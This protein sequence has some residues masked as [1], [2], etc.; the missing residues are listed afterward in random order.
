MEEKNSVIMAGPVDWSLRVLLSDAKL[1]ILTSFAENAER[2]VFALADLRNDQEASIRFMQERNRYAP[3]VTMLV[4]VDPHD[5][6]QLKVAWQF[7]ANDCIDASSMTSEHFAFAALKEQ[8]RAGLIHDQFASVVLDNIPNMVYVKNRNDELLYCNKPFADHKHL[9]QR[10]LKGRQATEFNGTTNS[11]TDSADETSRLMQQPGY[12][13]EKE[14][15]HR[16]NETDDKI[17]HVYKKALQ[18]ATCNQSVVVGVATD[19]TDLHDQKS[20]VEQE[21]RIDP[22]TGLLNRR[23][24]IKHIS[25]RSEKTKQSADV[26]T[27]P[28]FAVI[29]VDLNDFKIVNDKHGHVIGDKLLALVGL[30]LKGSTRECDLVGRIGGDEFMIIVDTSASEVKAEQVAQRI[31]EKIRMPY[32]INSLRLQISCSVGISKYPQDGQ[33]FEELYLKSDQAMY[34]AKGKKHNPDESIESKELVV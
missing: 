25:A 8:S 34:V 22:L 26:S 6:V 7:G 29:L 4:L 20:K 17:F 16:D 12:V 24:L 18:S 31:I 30:R 2:C 27:R 15:H 13:L 3:E 23:V 32:T 14:G 28:T 5:S 33:T 1:N 21:S 10:D 11:M 19:I 9:S